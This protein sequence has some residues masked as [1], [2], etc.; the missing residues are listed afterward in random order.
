MSLKLVFKPMAASAATIRNLLAV[1]AADETAGEINPTLLQTATA[2]N[3]AI[4]QGN[5]EIKLILAC[6]WPPEPLARASFLFM[7]TSMSANTITVGIMASVRVSFTM[8]AKSPAASENAYPA[9][10]TL[11]VSLTAVPDHKPY[12]I[13]LKPIA[14]PMMGKS[15][16]IAMSKRNVADMA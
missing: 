5:R 7:L 13:S 1:L 12:A 6:T 8:V 15:T 11:E 10:T 16:I 3:P 14:R 2:R 9:A 4:N